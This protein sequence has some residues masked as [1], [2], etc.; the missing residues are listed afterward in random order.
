MRLR[1]VLALLLWSVGLSVGQSVAT[2]GGDSAIRDVVKKYEE[3]RNAVD[4]DAV[5]ALFTPDS[6]QLV[7]SGEWR[8]GRDAVVRGTMASSGTTGGKRTLT[9]ESIRYLAPDVAIAD[10]RYDLTGLAGG[11]ERHMWSTF[12]LTRKPDGWRIAAI[13]NM[14]PAA[15]APAA[16][17]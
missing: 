9:V 12:L 2:G 1:L 10:A 3:A 17:H 7:S 8:K 15:P 16:G 14:L 5:A 13:R 6:D 11:Q 4:A